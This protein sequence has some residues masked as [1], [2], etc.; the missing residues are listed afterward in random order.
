MRCH[1]FRQTVSTAYIIGE[2]K[3]NA[4]ILVHR[5]PLLDQWRERLSAFLEWDPK[6][7]GRI[8][9]WLPQAE[10]LLATVPLKIRQPL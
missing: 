10:T 3:V 9:G 7:I 8:V 4:L 5:Q 6:R 1:R 2:R